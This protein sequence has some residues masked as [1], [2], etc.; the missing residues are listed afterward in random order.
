MEELVPIILFLTTGL[1]IISFFYLRMRERQALIEKGLSAEQIQAMYVKKPGLQGYTL[2]KIG[3]V[4][5]FF[6]IGLGVGSLFG[7]Y[8]DNWND[9]RAGVLMATSIFVFTGIGFIV[10]NL[11]GK[12]LERSEN[13]KR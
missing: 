3:I 13:E 5:V 7:N 1:V 2:I 8:E 12:K 4:L 11:V 6:G 10:A 9:D